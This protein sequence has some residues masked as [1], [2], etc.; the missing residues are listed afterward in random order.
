MKD[1][2]IPSALVLGESV[3]FLNYG[4]VNTALCEMASGRDADASAS[5]DDDI[6]FHFFS[7]CHPNRI[8]VALS[9]EE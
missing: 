8:T 5:Y 1:A 9:A 2:R 3:F 7:H 6:V 4:Y